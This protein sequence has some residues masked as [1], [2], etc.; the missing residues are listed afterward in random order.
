MIFPQ[1][2]KQKKDYLQ[3]EADPLCPLILVLFSCKS[4]SEFNILQSMDL[5]FKYSKVK[6][7]WQNKS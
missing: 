2:F 3:S 5:P 6:D 7:S 4:T 1:I